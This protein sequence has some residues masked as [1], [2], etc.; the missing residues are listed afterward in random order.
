MAGGAARHFSAIIGSTRLIR[1]GMVLEIIGIGG[2]AVMLSS[3]SSPWW[4]SIPLIIYGIGVGFD[5]AQLTNV[6]LEDVPPERSGG[7]SSVTSTLRQVGSTLGSA[8]LGTVLFVSLGIGLSNQLAENQP[9]LSEA[10]R[11][12]I[13]DQV[14]DSSGEAIIPLSQQPGQEQVVADAK[15]AYTT[16]VRIMAVV[17]GGAMVVGLI[18][19]FGL[20]ADP[21]R[22]RRG[23][24]GGSPTSSDQSKRSRG[25]AGARHGTPDE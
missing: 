11:T 22:E 15:E 13:V 19:S 24:P 10:D 4:L 6:I 2:V 18:A 16:A 3:T 25:G 5:T 7:A 17:A 9:Q 23:S 12:S 1:V 20:P 21:P 14:V 8:V